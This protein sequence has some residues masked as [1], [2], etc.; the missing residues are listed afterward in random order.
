MSLDPALGENDVA[1]N[2]EP[3]TPTIPWRVWRFIQE[4]VGGFL[5]ES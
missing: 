4:Q 2:E 5:E 1:N 3:W